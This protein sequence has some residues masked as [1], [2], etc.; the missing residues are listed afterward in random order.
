MVNTRSNR[1]ELP[2]KS[3]Y[4]C[5]LLQMKSLQAKAKIDSIHDKTCIKNHD[6]I[7]DPIVTTLIEKKKQ[8]NTNQLPRGAVTKTL[9]TYKPH[10][11]CL[12]I[13]MMKGRL[14]R[15]NN[16]IKQIDSTSNAQS[17]TTPSTSTTLTP[18]A[19][20]PNAA[21]VSIDNTNSTPTPT[22]SPSDIP[23]T[24]P[25]TVATN[26][27]TSKGKS[28]SKGGRPV[29]STNDNILLSMKCVSAAKAEIF[30][31]YKTEYD[32]SK[33]LGHV[34]VKHGTYDR[35]HTKVRLRR[36]LPSSFNFPYDTVKKGCQETP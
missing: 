6:L 2:T 29:G 35:I 24:S 5:K 8:S 23:T 25:N 33:Q 30:H 34:K 12:T 10:F 28:R 14:K 7:L 4:I 3:G 27:D 1:R 36:N 19:N 31:L 11:P 9:A 20:T 21:S 18:N 22:N 15:A 32:K 17:V 16:K 26:E 13:N